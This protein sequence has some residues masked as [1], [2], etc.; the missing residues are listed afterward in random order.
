[1]M[2]HPGCKMMALGTD[3]PEELENA[4]RRLNTLYKS[5]P[6]LLSAG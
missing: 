2:V 1:M 3:M 5:L 4:F 6:A